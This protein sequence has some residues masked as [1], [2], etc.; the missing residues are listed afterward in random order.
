MGETVNATMKVWGIP[1]TTYNHTENDVRYYLKSIS[2]SAS[3]YHFRT[4]PISI[5]NGTAFCKCPKLESVDTSYVFNKCTEQTNFRYC[6]AECPKLQQIS[7]NL[8][9]YCT[10]VQNF[11]H[12]FEN[13]GL[14]SIPANLFKNCTEVTNFEKCFNGNTQVTG[15][16]P[17]LWS[18]HSKAT[19]HTDCFTGCTQATNWNEALS[20]S[21]ATGTPS[22]SSSSSS[23]AS[24]A[25]NYVLPRARTV[26]TASDS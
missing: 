8:F 23:S 9:K 7:E 15:A 20:N 6:F 24:S 18:T 10:K 22:P 14:T 21:W 26:K 25:V 19:S 5:V 4:T 2:S 17:T 13:C 3:G 12:T 16:L 1:D 11:E